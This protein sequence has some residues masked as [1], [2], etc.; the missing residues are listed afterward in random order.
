MSGFSRMWSQRGLARAAIVA[1]VVL[2][3]AAAAQAACITANI[4]DLKAFNSGDRTQLRVLKY[5]ELFALCVTPASSGFI[6]ILDTPEAGDIEII[7]PNQV[8][9]P[10]EQYAAVE[11][12][13]EYCF[14]DPAKTF[15]LYQ[16]RNEGSSG[17]L[18]VTMTLSE[19]L[20]LDTE[21]WDRPEEVRNH[22]GSHKSGGAAC[23]GRDILTIS[24]EAE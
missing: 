12:G 4:Y 19:D 16:P 18:A 17:K 7:Y 24:Y 3:Q 13:K 5:D 2:G 1:A 14:G 22:L 15:P 20:Q 6:Q 11:G 21:D 9:T 23:T 10:G 8:L